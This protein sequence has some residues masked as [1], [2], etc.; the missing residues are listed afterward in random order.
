MCKG[1]PIIGIITKPN[2][3]YKGKLFTQQIVYNGIRNA[4][5]KNNGLPIGILP[6]KATDVFCKS[7][8]VINDEDFSAKELEDLH[9]LIDKCDGI[10]LQGGMSSCNYEIEAAKYAIKNDIPLIG[11]CAGFN[12]IIRAMG[13]MSLRVK[14]VNITKRMVRLRTRTL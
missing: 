9:C 8:A 7:D 14:I 11:I 13:G 1:K 2:I 10:I 3:F 6:T 4:V 12:N 5:L